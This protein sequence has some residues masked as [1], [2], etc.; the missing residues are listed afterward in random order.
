MK[1]IY[2]SVESK[3]ENDREIPRVVTPLDEK[4]PEV[5]FHEKALSDDDAW[6]AVVDNES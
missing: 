1:E 2:D 4:D 5:F 3:N 6:E